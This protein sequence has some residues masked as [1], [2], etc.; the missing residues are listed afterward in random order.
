MQVDET[1]LAE[2]ESGDPDREIRLLVVGN[3]LEEIA[4][5]PGGESLKLFESVTD[6]PF[7]F[8][9]SMF[10]LTLQILNATMSMFDSFGDFL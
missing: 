6:G 1:S 8:F 7:D 5:E 2:K 3:V 10:S 9:K 4:S